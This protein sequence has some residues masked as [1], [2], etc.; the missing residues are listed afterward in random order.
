MLPSNKPPWG[1]IQGGL[2]CKNDFFRWGLIRGGL[3]RGFTVLVLVDL[4]VV[5]YKVDLKDAIWEVDLRGAT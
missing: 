5:I 4:R 1:L 3:I 2:I